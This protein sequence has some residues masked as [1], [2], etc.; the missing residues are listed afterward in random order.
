MVRGR[1]WP[2]GLSSPFAPVVVAVGRVCL[3]PTF[4]S[5]PSRPVP[6]PTR[7]PPV[8]GSPRPPPVV[9]AASLSL[10]SHL[11]FLL[12]SVTTSTTTNPHSAHNHYSPPFPSPFLARSCRWLAPPPAACA[13]CRG[14]S[15]RARTLPVVDR[16]RPR[17]SF[18]AFAAAAALRRTGLFLFAPLLSRLYCNTLVFLIHSCPRTPASLTVPDR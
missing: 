2:W 8:S 1:S 5:H 13:L 6:P 3:S 4:P 18:A 7:P 15:L 14:P 11:F 16:R 9:R 12:L 10:P 17:P